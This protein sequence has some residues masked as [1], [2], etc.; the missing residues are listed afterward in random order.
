[1]TGNGPFNADQV[2]GQRYGRQLHQAQA[3]RGRTDRQGLFTAL[4]QVL[5][6]QGPVTRQ[7]AAIWIWA[8]PVHCSRP[9]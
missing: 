8:R 9:V 6:D 4:H 3:R 2:G 1:M 7:R 5:L